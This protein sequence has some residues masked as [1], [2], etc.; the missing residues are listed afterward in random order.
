MSS[1]ETQW[2]FPNRLTETAFRQIYPAPDFR[3]SY[4]EYDPGTSFDGTTRAGLVVSLK[5][6]F[7]YQFGKDTCFVGNHQ[8]VVLPAGDYKFRVLSGRIVK[9]LR[10]WD[11]REIF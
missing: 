11:L 2:I 10:V 7:E 4:G 1:K 9:V 5:G 6:E 8:H 3:V